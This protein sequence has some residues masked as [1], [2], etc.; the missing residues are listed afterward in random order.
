MKKEKGREP[1]L[2][3]GLRMMT[4]NGSVYRTITRT[5]PSID[6]P[7]TLPKKGNNQHKINDVF[8]RKAYQY[9]DTLTSAYIILQD[10]ASKQRKEIFFITI[11]LNDEINLKLREKN[12]AVNEETMI[13]TVSRW[14]Y[15]Y[16]YITDAIVVLE[17]CSNSFVDHHNGSYPRLHL[18]IITMLNDRQ[19]KVALCDLLRN[20]CMQLKIQNYWIDKRPY[21]ELDNWEEEQFGHIPINEVDPT[22]EYWLNT[23]VKEKMNKTTGEIIKTVYRKLPVCLRGVDYMSKALQKP[24]GRGKNYTLIGLKGYRKRREELSRIATTMLNE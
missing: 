4:L 24:I 1:S 21:T 8:V 13:R 22:A 17:E 11:T 20:K 6:T 3:K 23:Y 14:L 15:P 12:N 2:A 19:R 18:H 10:K 9:N 5:R 16:S 7:L